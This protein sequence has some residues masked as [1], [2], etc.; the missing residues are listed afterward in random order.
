[1]PSARFGMRS[2]SQDWIACAAVVCLAGVLYLNALDNPFVFDDHWLIVEN[3]SL[4]DLDLRAILMYQ[5][6][7]PMVNL[8]YALDSVLFG[9]EPF[10]FHLTNVLL[11]MLNVG[12]LYLVTAQLAAARLSKGDQ[13]RGSD[14]RGVHSVALTAAILFA[15][16]PLMTQAVGYI[17]GRSEVLC[18]SFFLFALLCACRWMRDSGRRWLM[19]AIG[20]W[21]LAMAT[22]ETA[23][24]F[25]L[26][27]L[28]CDFWVFSDDHA[29]RRRRLLTLHA[30]LFGIVAVAV[31]VR[32]AVL[33]MVERGS[34]ITPDGQLVLVA[35]DMARR[36]LWML[37][38]PAQQMIFHPITPIVSWLDPRGLFGAVT[39]LLL[40]AAV[41]LLRRSHG[42]VSVGL[43]W[44]LALLVPSSMLLVLGRAEPFSEHRVYL[45][46]CG[47]FIA[48]GARMDH[49]ARLTTALMPRLLLWACAA[50][51]LL[52]LASRTLLRNAVWGDPVA[53][54]TEASAADPEHWLPYVPLGEELHR[55]DRHEEAVVAFATAVKLRPQER[56]T[57]GKLGVCLVETGRL[58][59]ATAT[60]ETLGRM[61]SGAAES[62]YGLGLVAAAA[63]R[64]DEARRLLLQAIQLDPS[65]LA[66]R[67]V[68]T[69]IEDRKEG[70][71]PK[72]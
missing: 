11:H 48:L 3:R 39:V 15:V 13:S 22:K 14:A 17:S 24:M 46:S 62:A 51:L 61:D 50:G 63:G 71:P 68:L 32:L 43:A 9:R 34:E 40:I 49:L 8:S 26:V 60:F 5:A 69:A 42:L 23:A 12:L 54:W 66:A 72:R 52:S 59:A 56:G 70:G 45:A 30:P 18:A 7:R 19:L 27:V 33:A 57:Y 25:P 41:W 44:F 58:D 6:S 4:V 35:L 36:Y 29:G 16:H 2:R 67:R 64:E 20:A 21:L 10:G 65:N 55:Q 53:L 31:A 1:M 28:A 47:L 38:V 37:L